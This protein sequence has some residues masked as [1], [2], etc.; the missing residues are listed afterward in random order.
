MPIPNAPAQQP[1]PDHPT[2]VAPNIRLAVHEVGHLIV[3]WHLCGAQYSAHLK[4]GKGWVLPGAIKPPPP[5]TDDEW[6]DVL[7]MDMAGRAA[8]AVAIDQ[9]LLAPLPLGVEKEHGDLGYCPVGDGNSD[10]ESALTWVVKVSAAVQ[11]TAFDVAWDRAVRNV[12]Q[13]LSD[14]MAF[15]NQLVVD[16]EIPETAVAAHFQNVRTP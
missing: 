10:H 13:N 1:L 2:F 3:G 9:G 11:P 12:S 14:I 5:I 4:N 8:V 16:E 7:A 6:I 15:A